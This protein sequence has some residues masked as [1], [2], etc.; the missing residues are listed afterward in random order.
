MKFQMNEFHGIDIHDITWILVEVNLFFSRM[1]GSKCKKVVAM[2]FRELKNAPH[3]PI[4]IVFKGGLRNIVRLKSLERQQFPMT[5]FIHVMM[6]CGVTSN[7]QHVPIASFCFVLMIYF[8]M[9]EAS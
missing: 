9:S 1:R 7:G 8:I 3:N 2:V 5:Y 6:A 4:L